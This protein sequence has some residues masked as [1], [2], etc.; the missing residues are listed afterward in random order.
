MDFITIWDNLKRCEGQT[1]ATVRGRAFS[2]EVHKQGLAVKRS[3]VV[4]DRADIEAAC[5]HFSLYGAKNGN[6]T[7]AYINALLSDSR[8]RGGR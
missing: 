4:L 3:E 7:A 2:Y 8:I 5:H 6:G 1:F